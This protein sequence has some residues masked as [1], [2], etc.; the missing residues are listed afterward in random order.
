[1]NYFKAIKDNFS[2][3][4]KNFKGEVTNNHLWIP[5]VVVLPRN[6][7][8]ANRYFDSF[9]SVEPIDIRKMPVYTIDNRIM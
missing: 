7:I 3:I 6:M 1:M 9:K 2:R 8:L 4:V 5:D